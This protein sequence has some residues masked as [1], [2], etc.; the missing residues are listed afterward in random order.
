MAVELPKTLTAY[1]NIRKKNENIVSFYYPPDVRQICKYSGS[2][3]V[4]NRSC[5][6]VMIMMAGLSGAGKSTTINKLFNDDGLCDT[7][8]H[9]SGTASVWEVEAQLV[10][11]NHKPPLKSSLLFIDI[12]GAMD[13][14]AAMRKPNQELIQK[15]LRT[16]PYLS[17]RPIR[18]LDTLDGYAQPKDKRQA[19]SLSWVN[20]D[21]GWKTYEKVYPN[22]ILF[23]VNGQD[24]R[25]VG[26]NSGVH[27]TLKLLAQ[28]DVVDNRRPNLLVVVSFASSIASNASKYTQR[29]DQITEDIRRLL[30]EVF[31]MPSLY[32]TRVVFVENDADGQELKKVDNSEFYMLPDGSTSHLNLIESIIEK[33]QSNNDLLG[34]LLCGW[35]FG[36]KCKVLAHR[37]EKMT[38]SQLSMTDEEIAEAYAREIDQM[39]VQLVKELPLQYIAHGYCPSTG[40]LKNRT[41]L[42]AC[43]ST[44]D[45]NLSGSSFSTHLEF[46][47]KQMADFGLQHSTEEPIGLH[48]AYDLDSDENVTL[49]DNLSATRKLKIESQTSVVFFCEWKV[50]YLQIKNPQLMCTELIN[51]L[52]HLPTEFTG[53]N[54]N[55]FLLFFNEWGSHFVSESTV[56]GSIKVMCPKQTSNQRH[57]NSEIEKKIAARFTLLKESVLTHGRSLSVVDNDISELEIK[58]HGGTNPA[59]SLLKDLTPEIFQEWIQ[60]IYK[61]PEELESSVKLEPYYSLIEEGPQRTSLKY[62]TANYLHSQPEFIVLSREHFSDK[63][64]KDS[65]FNESTC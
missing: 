55:D 52:R 48:S 34:K 63:V 54:E 27:E 42:A 19:A 62:A 47:C 5:G 6:N 36:R 60:S 16:T 4:A 25:M 11:D 10:I 2:A 21:G 28:L 31:D 59:I 24:K 35:Y 1:M 29:V 14:D 44:Q 26:K 65:I 57:F 41:I 58:I 33:F 7:S 8:T 38:L 30:V 17:P 61:H 53:K 43:S 20:K 40:T 22:L 45:V 64:C 39:D 51:A 50:L 18:I 23:T 32:E 12:P 9:E 37:Q 49:N 46:T 13:T 15:Y 3:L 56:G